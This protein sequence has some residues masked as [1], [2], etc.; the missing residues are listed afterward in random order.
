MNGTIYKIGQG[1]SGGTTTFYI[2]TP[3]GVIDGVNTVYTVL[4]SIRQVINFFINGEE[5]HP[6]AY[7]TATN[8]ITFVTPLDASLSTAQFTI[9][10]TATSAATITDHLTDDAGNLDLTN[11]DGTVDITPS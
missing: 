1:G 6:L 9:V 8:E 4:H 11:D 10:Y 7:D 5:I 3:V 2:E